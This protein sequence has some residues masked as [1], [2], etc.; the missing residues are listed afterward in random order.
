MKIDKHQFEIRVLGIG[1]VDS[2]THKFE[3]KMSSFSKRGANYP[4]RTAQLVAH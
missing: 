3:I 2:K 1:R 4:V